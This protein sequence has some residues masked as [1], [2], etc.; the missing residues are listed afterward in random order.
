MSGPLR[1]QTE[2]CWAQSGVVAG[3]VLQ[4]NV[5]FVGTA[6][7]DL[8]WPMLASNGSETR[9]LRVC[10]RT[11]GHVARVSGPFGTQNDPSG[12]APSQKS[13]A[14]NFM[15]CLGL[16]TTELLDVG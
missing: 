8:N 5:D 2:S 4:Q 7:W 16:S 6:I 12:L 15:R 13:C 1:A 14:G 10:L 3:H 11:W 9:N